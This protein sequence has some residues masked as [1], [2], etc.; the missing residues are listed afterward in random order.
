MVIKLDQIIDG[1]M[2]NICEKNFTCSG[3]LGPKPRLFL[4][5]QSIIVNHEALAFSLCFFSVPKT[6]TETIE[7]SKLHLIKT[8]ISYYTVT[9][10]KSKQKLRVGS[11]LLN[12]T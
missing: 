6:Y 8:K 5:H 2:S 4:N 3:R 1:D 10:S 9:L 12:K 7:N 11:S